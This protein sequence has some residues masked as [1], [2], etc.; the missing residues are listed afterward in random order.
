MAKC[1]EKEEYKVYE[2]IRVTSI[3]ENENGKTYSERIAPQLIPVDEY[4]DN[5]K[6]G[7]V[8]RSEW[9]RRKQEEALSNFYGAEIKITYRED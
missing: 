5:E 3:P 4:F 6:Y 2:Y 9:A 1:K 8:S 7:N